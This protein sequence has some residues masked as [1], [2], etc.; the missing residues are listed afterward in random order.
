MPFELGIACALKLLHPLDYEVFVLDA[1]PYRLDKTLSDYKGRDPLIHHG[2]SDGLLACLLDAFVST[3]T[4]P[5]ADV[6][7]A[8]RVLSDVASRLK[9]EANSETIFRA[10]LFHSL[11]RAATEIAIR[12]DFIKPQP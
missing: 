4:P 1:A 9:D 12:F 7:H 2:S 5:P 11:L 3:D 10:S 6:R 8:L